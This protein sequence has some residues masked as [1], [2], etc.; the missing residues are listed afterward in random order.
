MSTKVDTIQEYQEWV[1]ERVERY[2]QNPEP[3]QKVKALIVEPG[4]IPYVKEIGADYESLFTILEGPLEGINPFGD[5]VSILCN[6]YSKV[7]GLPSNRALFDSKGNVVE[8]IAGTF[9]VV[10]AKMYAED[11][12]SLTDG[13]IKKYRK[14]FEDPVCRWRYIL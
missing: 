12:S 7:F 5:E 2:R 4:Q 3:E 6:E 8:I 13:D 14:I 1:M 10:G 11:Y 9:I